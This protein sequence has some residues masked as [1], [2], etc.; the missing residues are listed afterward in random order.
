[1]RADQDQWPAGSLGTVARKSGRTTP[2]AFNRLPNP[3]SAC[4]HTYDVDSIRM[5]SSLY[6]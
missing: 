1:M 4:L 6:N 3:V 2:P 5:T